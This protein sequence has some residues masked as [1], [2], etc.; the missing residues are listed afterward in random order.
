MHV[1]KKT[2]WGALKNQ[3]V[4]YQLETCESFQGGIELDPELPGECKQGLAKDRI[5]EWPNKKIPRKEEPVSKALDS[6]NTG[7][8]WPQRFLIKDIWNLGSY[9]TRLPVPLSRGAQTVL[10]FQSHLP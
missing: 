5:A 6:T 3:T 7:E 9:R 10:P 4:I 1:H 2:R 8:K